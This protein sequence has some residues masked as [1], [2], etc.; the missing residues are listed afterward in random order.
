MTF[1]LIAIFLLGASSWA[2]DFVSGQAARAVIGQVSFS[3]REPGITA[4]TLVISEG[5][6]FVTDTANRLTTVDLAKIPR[7]DAPA[8]NQE[9]A[10]RE[11]E[12]CLVCGFAPAAA[13]TQAFPRGS[14]AVAVYG[15]SV[16]V[17]D[18]P[19]H[20]VLV[21][22]DTTR[23]S[24][25][26]IPDVV[27]GE[28][29]NPSAISAETLMDP[30]SVAFDG[31][32]LF[33]GDAALRRVLVWN[34]LPSVNHQAAD[35]VL[36][37][38]DF[39]SVQVID[40]AAADNVG[41]PAALASDGANL[42]VADTLN[43]RILVFTSADTPLPRDAIRNS[44]RLETGPLAP[45]TLVT[46]TGEGLS[47]T[48]E[49]AEDDGVQQLP[50]EL[51]GT[52][53]IFD[54]VPL[55]LLSVSPTQIRAQI[56]YNLG[57]RSAASIYLRTEHA[58]GSVTVTNAIAATVAPANPGLFA[59]GGVDPRSGLVLHGSADPAGQPGAPVT[60]ENPARPGE[61]LVLWATGLGT[62][63]NRNDLPRPMMG[64]PYAGPGAPVANAVAALAG[65]RS[66]EISSA[67]L[68]RG[69]IGVYE[70]RIVLPADLPSNRKTEM[71]VFQ[72]GYV[73]NTIIFPVQRASE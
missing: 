61:T 46:I 18:A 72:N 55:P 39:T 66:A 41:R 9:I 15:N 28:K 19:N 6:L 7:P 31:K 1:R 54:G 14:A 13:T 37:Q 49:A 32:H 12:Q 25:F 56:P 58:D 40:R 21:W 17:A 45:G 50:A 64:V 35:A 3:A 67:T 16:V 33:V 47:D 30:I 53:V 48:S 10:P 34:S 44:A 57:D 22:R 4:T 71:S 65:G 62:L 2:A 27:L 29:V 70:I 69:A 42:F 24:N 36:G 52:R 11:L 8:S 68:P 63:E 5:R 23:H 51:G 59:F 20:R 60:D 73:S 26:Q 38:A 43:R